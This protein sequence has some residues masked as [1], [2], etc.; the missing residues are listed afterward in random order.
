MADDFL[1]RVEKNIEWRKER[2]DEIKLRYEHT[3]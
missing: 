1:T 3:D 2:M